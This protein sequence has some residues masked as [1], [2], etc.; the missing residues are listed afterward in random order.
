MPVV[1]PFGS[2]SSLELELPPEALVAAHA[3]PRGA[4]VRDPAAAVQRA[5][6][7][8]LDFPALRQATV[9]GD[10]IVLA[11]DR[12]V[13]RAAEAIAAVTSYLVEEGSEADHI[14]ILQ[15]TSDAMDHD[16]PRRLLPHDWRDEVALEVHAPD[17]SGKLALLGSS[18]EG[19]PVYLN[20]T[21]LDADLVVP[22]GC[23]RCERS[24]GYYGRYGGLYPTFSD[25]K[26]QQ[27]FRK[28]A[29]NESRRNGSA[30]RAEIDEIGWLLGTQFTVQVLPGPRDEWLDVL[31]GEIRQVFDVGA[32]RCADAW[33]YEVPRRASLVIASVSGGPGQQTWDNVGRALAAASEA[34]S[35]G[36]AIALCTELAAEP[37]PAVASLANVDDLGGALRRIRRDAESDALPAGALARALEDAKIYLL[38]RLDESLVEDLGMAVV[39]DAREIA[40]L[41]RRH[42]SCTV[43]ASAQH[44]A[45]AVGEER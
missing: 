23:L 37:G 28:P 1:L 5:V 6:R 26:T 41:A 13:P 45:V 35:P 16:D 21:L 30:Q 25:A 8:P 4:A 34:A 14:T 38:S 2:D 42:E 43:L 17:V 7:E 10:R 24:P 44:A 31:A 39:A 33:T 15:S 11:L 20:R 29:K 12:G 22:V 3:A 32:R 18:R 27:R 19:K 40:R 36:G 9:P